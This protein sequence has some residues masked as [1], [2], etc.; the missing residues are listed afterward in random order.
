MKVLDFGLARAL[1]PT[2]AATANS[3]T[4]TNRATEAG[5]ILGTAAYMAPEQAKGKAVDKRADIWSFG[6]VVCEMLTGRRLFRGEDVSDTLA[7]VLK[8]DPDWS[9]LPAATPAAIRQLLRR[10]L[11]RDPKQRLRDIGEAR[12][13]IERASSGAPEV[14]PPVR[15]RGLPWIL[16][17]VFGLVAVAVVLLLW[18]AKTSK[19]MDQPLRRLAVAP[20]GDPGNILVSPDGQWLLAA[21][22]FSETG[23]GGGRGTAPAMVRRIDSSEWRSLP[24]TAGSDGFF[25][26]A[27]SRQ[28]GFGDRDA[29]KKVDVLGSNPRIICSN[30][31]PGQQPRGRIVLHG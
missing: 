24:G 12:I 13:A 10:C 31:G 29:I 6:V 4:M 15:G 22:G 18:R 17:G 8:T 3:P 5:V 30:N 16:A 2:G 21:A 28:I 19:T 27:D 23:G 20:P 14:S 25:W 26:S 11:E 7:E 1:D 9:A